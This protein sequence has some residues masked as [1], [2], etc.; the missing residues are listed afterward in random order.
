MDALTRELHMK[1]WVALAGAILFSSMSATPVLAGW[2]EYR[3][4]GWCHYVSYPCCRGPFS[5]YRNI[6]A[7]NYSAAYYNSPRGV[8]AGYLTTAYSTNGYPRWLKN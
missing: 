1:G 8:G 2:W 7:L 6:P 3:G 5:L 4:R